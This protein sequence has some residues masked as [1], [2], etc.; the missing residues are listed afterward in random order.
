VPLYRGPGKKLSLVKNGFEGSHIGILVASGKDIIVQ[1]HIPRVNIITEVFDNFP[2]YRLQREGQHRDV[3]R[4]LQH[5][6]LGIVN[7]GNKVPG[8]VEDGRPGGSQQRITHLLGDGL[9][10]ALEYGGENSIFIGFF[11][12]FSISIFS[13]LDTDL[14]R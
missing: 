2:A 8:L 6:A 5:S 13:I 10:A 12:H 9:K 4:L 7:T 11:F 1:D 3:L 14:H